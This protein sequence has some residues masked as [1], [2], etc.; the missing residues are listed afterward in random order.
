L[1]C[2]RIVDR[3][4]ALADRQGIEQVTMRSVASSLGFEVMSL[5]NHVANKDELL[6]A[7]LDTVIAEITPA[8]PG[9]WQPSLRTAA[10][11][12]HA[13]LIGHPWA[14]DLWAK[15]AV[16]P[17]RLA[18]MESLLAV[19]RT[20]GFGSD[21][22]YHGYH[23]VLLHVIGFTQQQLS[24][25][26]GVLAS[27]ADEFL[28]EFSATSYPH[29]AEHIGQHLDDGA[30]GTPGRDYEF[31]LDLILDGLARL[32]RSQQRRSARSAG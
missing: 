13:V 2:D 4:I 14:C 1:T 7:M 5:Y 11:S 24:Y 8:P 17:A 15:Q 22:A 3:A 6:A 18:F 16:G 27:R 32:K 20:S 25:T 26:S 19:L 29:L 23:A 10:L 30:H 12:A 9:P 21:L 28:A 31:V